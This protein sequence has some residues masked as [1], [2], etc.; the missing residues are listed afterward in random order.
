M[1]EGLLQKN[2][3][4][5]Y[6]N[7]CERR[8]LACSDEARYFRALSFSN[9]KD[10]SPSEKAAFYLHELTGCEGLEFVAFSNVRIRNPITLSKGVIL[11]PCFLNGAESEGRSIDDSLLLATREMEHNGRYV[12]DGWIP[13]TVWDK[14]NCW[15]G[16]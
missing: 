9:K 11:V 5:K 1:I 12:Y 10:L 8:G 13:I 16:Y 2:L 7:W 4:L 14:E 3:T 15:Q 6:N